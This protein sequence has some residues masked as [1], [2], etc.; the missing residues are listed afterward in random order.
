MPRQ[1]NSPS[2]S[3]K[4]AIYA[5]PPK[6]W[7]AA[8]LMPSLPQPSVWQSMKQ[9]FGFGAGSEV[10]HRIVGNMLSPPQQNKVEVDPSSKQIETQTQ[11]PYYASESY[12]QCIEYNNDHKEICKPFLS[13]DKSPWTQCMEMNFFRND[14]CT[15]EALFTKK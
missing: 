5:P 8:P 13:K 7:H 4:P 11:T 3:K 9:G 2:N 6:I 10:G 14:L 12:R 1:Q 15:N